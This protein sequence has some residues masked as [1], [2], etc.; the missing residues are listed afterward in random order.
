MANVTLL[1]GA[2]VPHTYDN[3]SSV[4]LPTPDSGTV[5]FYADGGGGAEFS[6]N[7]G[8]SL[9][10]VFFNTRHD[11]T[12]LDTYLG[13]INYPHT[14][15]STGLP[16]NILLTTTGG[17]PLVY[18]ASLPAAFNS[19]KIIYAMGQMPI[20]FYSTAEFD[21]SS[22][23][24]GLEVSQGW[25]M[26]SFS[27]GI[28]VEIAHIENSFID[29][30]DTYFARSAEAYGEWTSGEGGITPMQA[31]DAVYLGS[32]WLFSSADWVELIAAYSATVSN[33]GYL[34]IT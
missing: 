27:A 25:Q 30:K 14:D 33:D 15:P 31:G 17:T 8:D 32:A 19:A 16:Y 4:T 10:S 9:S 21:A 23:I 26:D 3:V 24:T 22:I 12:A 29:V 18:I 5:T 7:V 28:E 11:T 34:V 2:N 20:I 6:I 1:D 13:T